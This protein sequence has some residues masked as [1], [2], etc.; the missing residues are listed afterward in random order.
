MRVLLAGATGTFGTALVPRLLDAGHD[1]VGIGRSVHGAALIRE[2]GAA[3]LLVDV[4]DRDVLL[5]AL[6]GESFD[7]VIHQLTALKDLP[8]RHSGMAGTDRLRTEGSAALVEV[9]QATGAAR[10]VTASMVFGYGYSDHGPRVLTEHDP[11][12]MPN[13][14]A[15]DPHLIAMGTAERLATT[16]PG[17]GGVALRYGLFYGTDLDAVAAALRR[18]RLPVARRGGEIPFVHHTDAA[19]AT[20]SALERGRAGAA[21]N[22][23]DDTPAT[24]REYLDAVRVSR[25]TPRAPVV[26]GAVLTLAAPYGG[27]VLRTLSMRVSNARARAELAWEPRHRSVRDGVEAS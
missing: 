12:G 3:S 16:I 20:V 1:V 26:P 6:D 5:H 19:D 10:F 27:V 11:F 17:V 25:G 13:G 2:M 21:Y 9:A 4:L 23:V 24:F 8:T 7:A 22:V 14:D 15:F 18:R